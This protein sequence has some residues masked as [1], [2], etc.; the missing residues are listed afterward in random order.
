VAVTRKLYLVIVAVF[1][2][3][4]ATGLYLRHRAAKIAAAAECD[5]PAP[6]P[7]PATPPPAL[8]GFAVET[9]CGPDVPKKK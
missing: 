6:P 2:I 3:L 7:K 5:T 1:L 4:A 8:P 9:A